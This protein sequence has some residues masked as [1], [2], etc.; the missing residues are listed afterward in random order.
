VRA[1]SVGVLARLDM[2]DIR[3]EP[4]AQGISDQCSIAL[5]VPA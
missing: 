1:I 3:V 5:R 4:F 2:L